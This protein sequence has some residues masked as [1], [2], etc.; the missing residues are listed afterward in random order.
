MALNTINQTRPTKSLHLHDFSIDAL[1]CLT[2]YYTA[3]AFLSRLDAHCDVPQNVYYLFL[4]C[5]SL[6][7]N[8][9]DCRGG[10]HYKKQLCY[11]ST[12]QITKLSGKSSSSLKMKIQGTLEH[13]SIV[14]KIKNADTSNT[15][16]HDR[17]LSWLGLGT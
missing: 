16:V 7:E 13:I 1:A 9:L 5:K 6:A 11:W 17:S 8:V 15:H 10:N 4:V 12:R 3:F 14:L 2:M